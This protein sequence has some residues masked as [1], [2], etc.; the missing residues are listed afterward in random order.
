[1]TRGFVVFTGIT[2]HLGA[3]VDQPT[4]R[5]EHQFLTARV[6]GFCERVRQWE[7]KIKKCVVTVDESPIRMNKQS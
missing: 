4:M 1:M 3:Q 6:L 5:R 2:I 7:K